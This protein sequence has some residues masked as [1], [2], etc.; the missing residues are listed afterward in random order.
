MTK[1]AKIYNTIQ[2]GKDTAFRLV[3]NAATTGFEKACKVCD[4]ILCKTDKE[5]KFF[6]LAKQ[7]KMKAARL[8][9]LAAVNA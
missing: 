2:E 4:Y 8:N 9:Y 6:S 7:Q 5:P 3:P 1:E